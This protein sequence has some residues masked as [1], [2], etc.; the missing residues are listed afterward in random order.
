MWGP[1]LVILL[2]GTG[3]LLTVRTRF[4]Q[5]RK[6]GTSWWLLYR[7]ITGK[8]YESGDKGDISPYQALS[9]V[10]ANTV[11]MGNIAGVATAIYLG[12]PGAVF[13]MWMTALCGMATIY[14][15]TYL[16]V[17]FRVT[18]PDG[19]I[20]AGPMYYIARGLNKSRLGISLAGAFA[21]AGGVA[22]LLGD[23]MIQSNSIALVFHQSFGVPVILSGLVIAFLTALVT[24][25]GIRRIGQVAE[26]LVPFMV[27]LFVGASIVILLIKIRAVPGTLLLIFDSAFRPTAAL[28][29]FAGAG[30]IQTVQYGVSRGL[31]S[32]EAGWGCSPIYHGAAKEQNPER[33]AILSMNGVFIDTM[34]ICSMTALVILVT[35]V[36]TGGETSTALTAAAFGS[37][38]P[39]GELLVALC[40][41]LFGMSTLFVGSYYREQI[42]QFLFGLKSAQ[43]YRYLYVIFVF[44]G[45]VF[46]VELVWSLTLILI[47]FMTL[48]NLLGLIA[49]S[50]VVSSAS[51][52]SQ[53]KNN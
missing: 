20:A 36:W 15:E 28:G 2:L 48:P 38:L 27:L 47:A 18:A 37:V 45:A 42:L 25:G 24:I 43:M 31:Y 16:S 49:L 23:T 32:N 33:Q 29:G 41:L 11:G 12:G 9:S 35:G 19:S 17:R 6:F 14:S 52:E 40:S 22:A 5:F 30:M 50:G 39:H 44:L 10:I 53:G 1:W 3:I 4:I 46:R 21:M 7:G 13:W 51:G 34:V 26:K 8:G